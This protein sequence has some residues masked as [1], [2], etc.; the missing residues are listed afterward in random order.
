LDSFYSQYVDINKY[1]FF[2]NLLKNIEIYIHT[3]TLCWCIQPLS[4]YLQRNPYYIF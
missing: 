2:I 4:L 1:W 3:M